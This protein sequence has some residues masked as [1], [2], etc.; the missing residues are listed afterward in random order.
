LISGNLNTK[1]KFEFLFGR[2]EIRAKLPHGDWVYPGKLIITLR[3]QFL[4]IYFCKYIFALL[5][6]TLT[7]VENTSEF[8]FYR[9]IRIA[10]LFG[11]EELRS[12][13]VD[14]NNHI[15]YAGALVT[16]LNNSD[17]SHNN[18]LQLPKRLSEESWSN[19]FHIYEIEWKSGLIVTKVDGVQYGQQNVDNSFGKAVSA[20]NVIIFFIIFLNSVTISI[21][22]I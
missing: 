12:E 22:N 11:N 18:R 21:S 7:S 14:I 2:I 6:I 10:S 9:N 4:F 5:V 1:G 15:L 13:N 16:S 17:I 3:Y 20:L 19:S 8:G